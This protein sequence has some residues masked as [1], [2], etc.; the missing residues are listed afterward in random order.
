MNT[1]TE[2]LASLYVLDKLSADERRTFEERLESDTELTLLVR[3]LESALEDQ[4]RALPQHMA[5]GHVLSQIQNKIEAQA[6]IATP[7]PVITIPWAKFAGWGMVAALMFGVGL[8]LLFTS[9]NPIT[10][11][12]SNQSVV[13]IVRMDPQSSVVEVLPTVMPVDELENFVHLA[14]MVERFWEHPEQL[15][16]SVNRSPLANTL[17]SGYAVFDPQSKHGFIAIQK[18]PKRQEGKNYFLWLRDSNAN[19]LYRAGIIP[20][21]EKDQGLYF[22][23][24]EEN[25]PISSNSVAFFITE[26]D[27]A[28]AELSQPHGELVLG[29]DHI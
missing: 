14:Q 28:E 7:S 6:P 12:S 16:G 22:F 17:G 11:E 20:M 29:S 3:E 9:R 26:E 24:L 1:N 19:V 18:L 15:P 2:E 4:V 8:T 10:G 21:Q 13:L 5:P 25:S 23:E 27:T